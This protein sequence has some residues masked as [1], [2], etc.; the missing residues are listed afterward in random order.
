MSTAYETLAQNHAGDW[1][2]TFGRAKSSL[3]VFD[4]DPTD[5]DM[6]TAHTVALMTNHARN[7]AVSEQVLDARQEILEG[8]DTQ[9]SEKEL[10]SSVWDYIRGRVRFVQDETIVKQLF[11]VNDNQELLI[12]PERLLTMPQ[13]MGD[14]DDFSTLCCSLLMS[15]GIKCEFVTIAAD[16]DEPGKFSHVYCLATLPSGQQV[17]LDTSHGKYPGWESPEIYRKQVWPVFEGGGMVTTKTTGLHGIGQV[18]DYG[19]ETITGGA[20]PVSSSFDWGGIANIFAKTGSQIALAQFGQPNLQPNTYIRN[21]NGSVLTNQSMG[22]QPL[23]FAGG[24]STSTILIGV[25][26]LGVVLLAGRH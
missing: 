10:I 1:L 23:S 6:S 19:G 8:L 15:M 5:S 14:C 18:D 21:A 7:A 9:A 17:T 3:S 4:T 24:I 16:R 2:S 22:T 20:L 13:P 25:A 26:I 12:T 11:G